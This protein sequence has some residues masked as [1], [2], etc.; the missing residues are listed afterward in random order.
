M[1]CVGILSNPENDRPNCRRQ[2]Y[3]RAPLV[4]IAGVLLYGVLVLFWPLEG[5]V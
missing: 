2:P 4:V 5:R 3:D 1:D